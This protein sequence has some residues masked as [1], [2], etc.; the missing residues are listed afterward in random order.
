[1]KRKKVVKGLCIALGVIAALVVVLGLVAT[2]VLG[3]MVSKGVLYQNDGKDTHDN[4]VKQLE[5]WEYDLEGFL[6]AHEGKD[7][8]AEAE[9]GNRVPGTY[10]GEGNETCVV[11]VHGAGGD[12]YVMYPLAEQYL[13]RGY[14][15]ISIDQ[16]GSGVNP[17]PKV[18]FGIHESLDV[19]AM[20]ELARTELS[21]ETVFVHGQ[22]MG[23]QTV[24][25]YASNVTPGETGAADAVVLDSPVPGMEL[26]LLEMFGDGNTKDPFAR[27]LAASGKIYM[28]LVDHIDYDDAD[29]IEIVKKDQIPTMLI[30]SDRDEVCLPD[31]EEALYANIGSENKTIM[32][33]DSVHIEGVI[34]DPEG[35]MKG[36]MEFLGSIK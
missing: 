28:K 25:L 7:V 36:T 35:Y 16:R 27:Y 12:R 32:H 6:A 22:S 9:D 24:A 11:L 19:K 5:T 21:Y 34:V 14:D 10:F 30:V 33:V 8:T 31:Q 29:T 23:G 15:V 26:M 13:E 20:V 1:M 17:D 4:S 3:S 2:G 18:T